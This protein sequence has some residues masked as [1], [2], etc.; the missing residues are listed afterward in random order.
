[1]CYSIVP[2]SFRLHL[3]R[4][5]KDY[6][7]LYRSA[8]HMKK[9][10]TQKQIK[11]AIDQYQKLKRTA[12]IA[13]ELGVTQRRIQQI[14]AEFRKTGKHHVQGKPG[15]GHILPTAAETQAVLEAHKQEPVGVIRTVQNIQANHN[16]SYRR[17]YKIMKSHGLVTASEKKSK[18]RKYVRF[19]RKY[20]NAMR[21][22]DWHE[23][24]DP[25]FAGMNLVTYIDDSSRCIMAARLF[26]HATSENAILTLSDA[27]KQ[28]KVPATILSDNGSCFVGA[29]GRR[30]SVPKSWMPT[31]FEAELLD[32]GIELINSRPYHPQTNGKLERFHRSIEEELWH[33][34]SLSEYIQYYNERRLH[35]SLD[36][37]NRQT[38]LRAFSDR[39][40]T[41]EIRKN[42]P[43]WMEEDV[44]D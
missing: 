13:V 44:D 27:I 32:R 14:L 42:N 6:L 38:P 15:R 11:Y 39:E 7:R 5:T 30:K 41:E 10:L 34:E 28:F 8:K 21:H 37:K 16:I 22:V 29:S 40:A 36:M 23:M 33:Y 9:S 35:F 3:R 25:R 26:T 1:M 19:E 31:A 2:K 20:S 12:D 43:R 17:I 4:F 24:K 18:K